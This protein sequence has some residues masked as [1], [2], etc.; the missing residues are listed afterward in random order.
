[1]T[2]L[3]REDEAPSAP[4]LL[5]EQLH[6]LARESKRVGGAGSTASWVH[7]GSSASPP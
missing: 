4:L 2:L 5:F 3:R 6:R 7:G 1:M